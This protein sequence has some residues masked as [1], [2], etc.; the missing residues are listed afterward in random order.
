MQAFLAGTAE[1]INDTGS[2][3]M[4]SDIKFDVSNTLS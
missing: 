4:E 1:A 2:F 3:L